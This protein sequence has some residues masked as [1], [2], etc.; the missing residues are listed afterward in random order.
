V[1]GALLAGRYRVLEELGRGGMGVVHRG[2]DELLRRPVAIKLLP[3]LDPTSRR[4]FFREARAA[5]RLD[6][7]H[8]VRVFDAG[9]SE[10][11]A[12]LVMELIEG[13]TLRACS[14]RLPLEEVARQLAWALS[15]AH[16]R[17]IVH[18]DLK[19][20]N[21]LVEQVAPLRLKLMDFGLASVQGSSRLTQA[22]AIV[23]TFTYLAPE[24]ARG[25]PVDGRA[26]LY[27]LGVLLYEL[28]VGQPPFTGASPPAVVAQHLT[29]AP[30]PPREKNA[31]IAPAM[32]ALIL[33]LLAK[34]PAQRLP[35]AE[36]IVAWLEEHLGAGDARHGRTAMPPEVLRMGELIGR[37][38]ELAELAK[39]M[40][41]PETGLVT[42]TGPGGVGKTHL[43]VRAAMDLTASF[44]RVTFAPLARVTDSR[45]VISTIARALGVEA[46]VGQM[47]ATAVV[48]D[49][50]R[51]P[52]LLVLDNCEH[53]PGSARVVAELLRGSPRSRILATSR[54]RLRLEGER[55]LSVGPLGLPPVAATRRSPSEID[56]S[57]AIALFV[58]RARAARPEFVL[59]EENAGAVEAICRRL[60][61]LPLA[62][63]LAAARIKLLPPQA[64]EK[65]LSRGDRPARALLSDPAGTGGKQAT[66]A[67]AIRWSY[68]LLPTAER[69]LFRR[70]S[71][72]AGP[73]A[74]D[75]IEAV[76]VE[77][78]EPASARTLD[79]L[80]LLV[81]KSLLRRVEDFEDEACF[82]TLRTLREFAAG[83]LRGDE[84]A[85]CRF[86]HAE[87]Y[88]ALAEAAEPHIRSATNREVIRQLERCREDLRDALAWWTGTG[89]HLGVARLALSLRWF[90]VLRGSVSEGVHWLRQVAEETS[91][92]EPLRAKAYSA[93]AVCAQH[94][95][96]S[97]ESTRMHRRSLELCLAQGNESGAADCLSNLGVISLNTGRYEQAIELFEQALAHRRRLG[98]VG[99]AANC[100]INLGAVLLY[101]GRLDR[102][103]ANCLE[104]LR[105]KEKVGDEW[106][107]GAAIDN[108]GL[109]ALA[110]GDLDEAELRIE[111]AL[112]LWRTLGDFRGT[113]RALVYRGQAALAR[114][115]NE[116]ARSWFAEGAAMLHRI[117]A[118]P[119][120][121]EALEGLARVS[122]AEGD[123]TATARLVGASENLRQ[124]TG[125]ARPPADQAAFEGLLE[126]LHSASDGAV[127]RRARAEGRTASLDDLLGSSRVGVKS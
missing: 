93:G 1:T 92:P 90:W 14:S 23:G 8:I 126:Q 124:R 107:R 6:H 70:F 32:E 91:L 78:E 85:R 68:D 81:D 45:H 44:A 12:F 55:E 47:L 51:T 86:R 15:H 10:S 20:E 77:P 119:L 64:L 121:V 29:A 76:C 106:G 17:A 104:A 48:E 35:S 61:A 57:P 125:E 38:G 26:D 59:T 84:A 41:S 58:R 98:D 118:R 111:E 33:K 34:D 13:A 22:G 24:Q 27:S 11:A 37:D 89:N 36:S 95:G 65:E 52:T 30:I 100:L 40:Q 19:P 103:H 31:E 16:G 88:T 69:N 117:G 122:A 25:G 80:A 75:A 9:E 110:R 49:L 115:E 120:L 112:A 63:E 109:V 43:A 18:R 71:V 62:I 28:G 105:L 60:D 7:P 97:D 87:F 79:L 83:E 74:L 66:L 108:L 50:A 4:R 46:D 53:L 73:A 113:G 102:A 123:W 5:A 56:S 21:V 42:L 114:G 72:F 39:L 96:D 99:R 116:R 94:M 101:V 127:L 82:G 3:A 67:D 2:L 54:E